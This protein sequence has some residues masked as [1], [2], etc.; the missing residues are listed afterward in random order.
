MMSWSYDDTFLFCVNQQGSLMIYNNAG[1]P[2]LV[3]THGLG[4]EL[5]PSYHLPVHPV[6]EL[7]R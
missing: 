7:Q 6:I 3:S 2:L 5:G 4:I 1:Q